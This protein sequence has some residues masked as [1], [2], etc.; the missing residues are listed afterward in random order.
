MS[1]AHVACVI[2]TLKMQMANYT[3]GIKQTAVCTC[4]H[5]QRKLALQQQTGLTGIY[6]FKQQ[7]MMLQQYQYAK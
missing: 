2:Y 1:S 4:I 3:E 7:T 6:S 5:M